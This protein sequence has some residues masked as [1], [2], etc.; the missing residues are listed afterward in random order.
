VDITTLEDIQAAGFMTKRALRDN[1]P[2]GLF[3]VP[4]P[5]IIRLQASSGTHGKATVVGYTRADL[6]TWTELMARTMTMGG[7]RPGMLIH[8]AVTYG[9][10]TGGFGFHQ[11]AESIGCT[12]LPVSGG[13]TARQ[14]VLMNDMRPD[15]LVATPSYALAIA[16]AARHAGLDPASFGVQLGLFG[17]EGS[18]DRMRRQLDR[19]F[20]FTAINNYGLSE[21]CGPG[22]AGECVEQR[23]GMHIHE[24]HFLV[25][26]IDSG[27]GQV[28][29]EGEQG[30]LVLT[31]LTKEALPLI[32]YRTGDI[33][34]LSYEPCP[35]GRTTARI[36]ALPGRI[37]DMVTVRGV[38]VYPS[39]V[40]HLMLGV[41]GVAPHY[42]LVVDRPGVMDEV[43]LECEMA[44]SEVNRV[45]LGAEIGRLLQENMGLRIAVNVQEPGALPRS[46]G[47]AVR[48]ID[49][50]T[51]SSN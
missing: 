36:V 4:R 38:N 46:E 42:R 28:L 17:G 51:V 18:T 16:H 32:R 40:E 10:F 27:S 20:A 49:N 15:V 12:V 9:L 6:N 11:G 24:D 45:E 29:S 21:M 1:Y 26:V 7:V 8:N 23:D 35:C 14:V 47:K 5:E 13:F 33:G 39:N 3:A 37:D 19:E 30:E 43:T 48:V 22:V 2:F 34:Q 44:S 41:S 25:E 31:T 50:R